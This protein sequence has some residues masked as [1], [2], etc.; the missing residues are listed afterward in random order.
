MLSE[1]V[2][3]V[4]DHSDEH[5]ALQ[6]CR[7]PCVGCNGR[8]SAFFLAN[9]ADRPISV[10]IPCFKP[11]FEHFDVGNQVKIGVPVKTLIG[12]S[13]LVYLAPLVLMLLSAVVCFRFISQSDVAVAISALFGLIGGLAVVRVLLT[14]L[15]NTKAA[16]MLFIGHDSNGA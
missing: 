12:L 13:L 9:V 16:E 11:T 7:D 14:R 10:S 1:I 8:C 5:I 3:C 4:T 15:E 6:V 2:A